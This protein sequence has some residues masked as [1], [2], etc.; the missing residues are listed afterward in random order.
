MLLVVNFDVLVFV[1]HGL[2]LYVGVGS[3]ALVSDWR[4]VVKIGFA[5]SEISSDWF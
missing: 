5:W 2:G 4:F 3:P 1:R